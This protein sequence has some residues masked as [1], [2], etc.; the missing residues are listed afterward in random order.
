M[1][2]SKTKRIILFCLLICFII[3]CDKDNKTN[4]QKINSTTSV[5]LLVTEGDELANKQDYSLAI[6]KYYEALKIDQNCFLCYYKLAQVYWIVR[7]YES[8]V[9]CLEVATRLNPQWSL[10]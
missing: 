10:P 5:N 6:D 2:K 4:T 8:S 3:A 9:S 7:D 1:R